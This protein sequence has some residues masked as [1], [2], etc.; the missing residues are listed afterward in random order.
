MNTV[1]EILGRYA[2]RG[3]RLVPVH[4]PDAATRACSCGKADCPKPGKHPDGRHW[5]GGS[6]E[7]L[8]FEGRNVGVKLG[9]ESR[10]LADVDLDCNAAVA[11]APYLLPATDCGFG[12]GK[13]QT[14]HLYT[15]TDRAASFAKLE[16]PV[17][18][19][20]TATI[21]ELRWPE[22]D[23]AEQRFKSLQ[24]VFPPSLHHT[25]STLHWLR[26]GEPA[27]VTGAELAAAVR[28]VGAAV[29]LA[30]HAKPKKRHDLVLLIAN[31]LVRARWSDDAKV[32]R[33]LTAVFTARGDADKAGLIE[34]GEGLGAVKDARKRLQTGKPMTGLPAL[35]AMVDP[36]IDA[37][38]GDQVV[39]RVKEWL[40]VP[41]PPSPKITAG[42]GPTGRSPSAGGKSPGVIPPS[43]L[44]PYVPFPSDLLPPVVRNYVEATAAAM[45]CDPS[46]SALPALAALGAA[47]G[48][49]HVAS[50]KKGW[51]EPP[52]VWA[53]PIGRSGATKSPPYRDV[54]DLAEDIN[55]RLELEYEA[56]AADH[57]VKLQRWAD[58]KKAGEDPGA[59]P[60]PPVPRAFI[61]GDVTIEALVGDLQDNPR[62]LLIGQ[63]ELSAWIA[64]FVKYSGK[65]GASDLSRWLQLHGAGS[66][67]Y[68]R[69]TGD[70][71][72]VRIRGVG[73]SVAGTIQ[74]KILSR[75]LNEEFRA[76][77][78]LARLLLAMPPWRQ[79]R[80][81]EAEVGE[82][83]RGEFADLLSCL[84]S[85]P[86][87][88]WPDGRPAPHLVRL[89]DGAKEMFVAFYDAN[90][91]ALAT[92]DEDMGAAMSKLEGY[93]LRFALIFHCCR[94]KEFGRDARITAEDMA[95][96]IKLTEWFRD[97]AERVYLALGETAE[98]Q[99]VRQ[100]AEQV[101]R[102]AERR[103]G[104]ITVRGFQRSKYKKYPT[105]ESAEAA[106]ESLVA[107]GCGEWQEVPP[108]AT[109]G[110]PTR[111][112]APRLTLATL[113]GEE[114]ED[115][116]DGGAG[117]DTRPDPPPD[118][119]PERTPTPAASRDD[120]CGSDAADGA[121]AAGGGCGASVHPAAGRSAEVCGASVH[122]G[123]ET[124]E[125]QPAASGTDFTL[126][127]DPAGL[128]TVVK[129]MR[130][131]AG[132]AGVDTETTGLDPAR[133][134]VRLIQIAM[135]DDVC[136]IDLFA[137]A[138]PAAALAPL[139]AALAGKEVVGHNLTAF[140]L[141]FLARLGFAP[142]RVFDTA[143]ASRVVYA[144]EKQDHDLAAAVKRELGRE[145]DKREQGGD[146]CRPALT[147]TQLAYAAADV[148]VLVPLAESLRTKAAARNVAG[149]LELEMS[150]AVPV[151]RM[152]ARGVGFD[153]GAW[154]ALADVARERKAALA[155]E[156]NALVPNPACL[157]GMGGWNW[158]SNTADVPAAFAAVGVTLA[159][160]R[161]ET[162]AGID[163]PLARLLLDYREAAKRTGTYGREWAAEHVTGGRVY[164]TWNP[165]QAKTGRMSCSRPNLQQVPR[166][167]AYRRCFVARDGHVLVKCDFSQIELRIAARVTGDKRMLDAYRNGEDLHALTAARFLGV[168][169]GAV[170]K[171]A[172]Q[173]AKPVNF[174][175][176]Y[177]LGPRSLRLK[178]RADYGKD[179]TER[180]AKGFLNAFF[181]EYPGV[182]A[183]HDRL[184]RERAAAVWTLGGRRVA[185]EPDQFHGA[186]ANYVVQGTGGDGLKRALVLLWERR[187]ECPEAAVVLAVHD[188]VV[189]EVPEGEA[190]AARA[191]VEKCMTD[192]MAP[193]IAPVPVAVESKVGRT[194]A[195]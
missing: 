12:R 97:E 151:A 160:T 99:A 79:R 126:V 131:W 144:G 129:A 62:G 9:P 171:E 153:A 85:L 161:E 175:A 147:P 28:R 174:G 109:G 132:P 165:C 81:S 7:L 177:G 154:H 155:A 135:G 71:R 107:H 82:G 142:T 83:V 10:D 44:P 115:E 138:D 185:V 22:W 64:G 106:L 56:E 125:C 105:T 16:D 183:W 149:V 74:P 78:F 57:E 27:V 94:L 102:L 73:V 104:R 119:P 95:A 134:R 67:N 176:I 170:T 189:V 122:P 29:L 72:K 76:S 128:A 4:R 30:R 8:H 116:G 14:H 178:A 68:T 33:F 90:G 21:V 191:W 52:Y 143:L 157:P 136:L 69:K 100:L 110:H 98:Q 15:V 137:F 96:A 91:E 194:W 167:A 141:P 40:G 112:Y 187:A 192:A 182:R 55:D 92:A 190:D 35:R 148:A 46:F 3:W 133:D 172:R 195:G 51:K 117:V 180:Q 53:L 24:T 156:M 184:K 63:D 118:P 169:V 5:P 193:L 11:V 2:A 43:P 111:A 166:D 181:A 38:A 75:V 164:A 103:G 13:A 87:G 173:T 23:E 88:S 188:E 20:D 37:A 150:C 120:A 113:P 124:V 140:D 84:R 123:G 127:T 50:P 48:S 45:N 89:S 158:D 159:D 70:R 66:I 163:H 130:E 17:L 1:G 59:K 41:D 32:V 139:F 146:W 36:A 114:D 162:L 6:A 145:L 34:K 26:D 60:R 19:G 42:A 47:L 80:W 25:G 31:L 93:A 54:E 179:M 152:A 18:P 61:K 186:K 39:A 65:L 86:R 121:E 108:P 77:G 101:A 49:S 168:G 58:A